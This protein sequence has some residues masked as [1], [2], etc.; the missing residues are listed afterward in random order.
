MAVEV[1]MPRLG[2]GGEEG[3]LVEW[4][5]QD[6]DEVRPG[7]VICTVEGEKAVN[8]VEALDRGILRIPPNSPPPGVKVPVGT[9][10][11]YLVTPGE[12]HPFADSSIPV[13]SSSATRANENEERRSLPV[14]PGAEAA[15]AVDEIATT[16][17]LRGSSPPQQRVGKAGPAASPRAR[18]IARELGVEWTAMDGSGRTG[19]IV[20]RDVREA[21]T[22]I[23]S[24]TGA[25]R[26]SPI[27]RRVAQDLGVDLDALARAKPGLRITRVE[28]EEA[29]R[30]RETPRIQGV[31]MNGVRR[32]IARRMAESARSVAPVT[33]TTE[34]DATDLVRLREQLK[35]D[36]IGTELPVPTYNDLLARIVAVALQNHPSLNA[37]LEGETIVQ[38]P[39]VNTGIAVDTDRGLL[40]PVIRDV[41]NKS[42]GQLARESAPLIERTRAGRATA[43]DLSGGTFTITNLGM[44]EIDAFTPIVNLPETAILG[45]GRIVAK[46]VVLDEASETI[47]VRKMMALSLTF[48]HRIVDGAP[49]ARFLQEV[50]R[51]V[52]RPT[53]LV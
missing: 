36:R 51:L 32:V 19:R 52:E 7:E 47:A 27:V 14:A 15:A 29:A 44:Y 25:A 18:H 4:L 11:A 5:K 33:L 41:G 45:V 24:E 16:P 10:L 13:T 6:G 39:S 42:I 23:R 31:P 50:K 34:A 2:W 48:D 20:E 37:S 43:E 17:P 40:V 8:E 53:L 21:A 35:K 22:L 1:V 49:A 28:V 46:P 9:V 3:S 26:F 38:H 12:K 30:A